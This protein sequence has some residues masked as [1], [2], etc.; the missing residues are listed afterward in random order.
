ME[1]NEIWMPV[2]GYED[3]YHVSDIGRIKALSRI[4]VMP[5]IKGGTA[6]PWKEKILKH[7]KK[8]NGYR[9]VCM[10]DGTGKRN[11]KRKY[12]HRIVW[13]AFNGQIPDGFVINHL[14]HNCT[15][16]ILINLEIVSQRDNCLH[17]AK[18]QKSSRFK[19]VHRE[20]RTGYWKAMA[21]HNGK[22][23][24]LGKFETEEL[25]FDAYSN[26]VRALEPTLKHLH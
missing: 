23:Q 4:E 13:E 1:Q 16:N 9:F 11:W 18:K 10:Y 22:K 19:G 3:R 7:S 5:W 2:L 24:Y 25:A 12:V 6:R 21:R 8:D 15:N 14:D 26:F 20:A 17:S